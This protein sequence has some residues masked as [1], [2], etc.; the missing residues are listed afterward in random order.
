MTQN[1]WESL[2]TTGVRGAH[3]CNPSYPIR[4]GGAGRSPHPRFQ[5]WNYL[6]VCWKDPH[7]DEN[8]GLAILW[9]SMFAHHVLLLS[10]LPPCQLTPVSALD[11]PCMLWASMTTQSYKLFIFK[12]SHT[13]P[14]LRI[15][16]RVWRMMQGD[17]HCTYLRF[18]PTQC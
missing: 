9:F 2:N 10:S 11:I 14:A 4:Q 16:P 6:H 7:A 1:A 18:L 12:A 17:C 5:Y 15:E 3:T 13:P 8:S